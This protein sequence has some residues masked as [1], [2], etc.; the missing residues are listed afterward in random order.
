MSWSFVPLVLAIVGINEAD[1]PAPIIH[2][3]MSAA[4]LLSLARNDAEREQL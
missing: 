1:L 4:C 3:P 2:Q